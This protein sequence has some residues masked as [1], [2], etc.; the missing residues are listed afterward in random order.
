M[1]VDIFA[2]RERKCPVCGKNFLL[3]YCNIYKTEYRGKRRDYC[4]YT[5]FRTAQK[6]LGSGKKSII[7]E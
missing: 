4:S 5:C 6:I 2:N 7:V 3:P 1:S